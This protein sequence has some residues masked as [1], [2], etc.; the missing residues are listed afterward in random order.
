MCLGLAGHGIDGLG[1]LSVVLRRRI[2]ELQVQV[3]SSQGVGRQDLGE[4]P[5]GIL[6]AGLSVVAEGTGKIGK[7]DLG[8]LVA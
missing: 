1:D 7:L 6:A 2:D 3:G 4:L 5:D 8:H